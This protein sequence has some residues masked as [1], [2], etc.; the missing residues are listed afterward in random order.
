MRTSAS[1]ELDT[2]TATATSVT[3]S[4]QQRPTSAID[5]IESAIFRSLE[6]AKSPLV[7]ERRN[8]SIRNDALNIWT[9]SA[10][11][12]TA[13]RH[14]TPIVLLH[15]FATGLAMWLPNI[16]T[17]CESRPLHAIDMLGFGRSSRPKFSAD[18][19]VA[20]SQ[21]VEALE[22]WRKAMHL[23]HIIL[24]AHCFGAYIATAYALKYPSHVVALILVGF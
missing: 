3:T 5:D 4:Q 13:P 16:E 8:V 18:H 7:I 22:D 14:H 21:F 2:S 20:E 19:I 10:V 12:K 17:L 15:G 6:S 11:N 24:L 23:P 9:L 1:T